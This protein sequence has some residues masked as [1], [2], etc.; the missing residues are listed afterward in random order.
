MSVVV[1]CFDAK[2]NFDDNAAFRQKE[3]FAMVGAST[4]SY[5]QSLISVQHDPSVD[6]PRES[7]AAEH[8][9]N[10]IGLDGNI[11]CLGTHLAVD[12]NV[13]SRISRHS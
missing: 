10:Y 4:R 1:C 13:Y 5:S 11:G 8:G 6:D 12:L 3:I 9:L 2:L 7:A